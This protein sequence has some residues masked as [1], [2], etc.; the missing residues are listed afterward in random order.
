MAN[1]PSEDVGIMLE[2][3][4]GFSLTYA[5]NLFINKQPGGLPRTEP[6][7]LIYD[8]SGFSPE[9]TGKIFEKPTIMVR[10][11]GPD[12]DYTGA[13]DLVMNIKAALHLRTPDTVGGSRYMGIW[14]TGEIA[15]VGYEDDNK[16]VFTVNFRIHR[17]N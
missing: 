11:I 13:R 14:Q 6:I 5:T 10:V 7:A 16:P 9:A 8:S 12:G 3:E 2:A 1:L 17:T 4:S 15:F